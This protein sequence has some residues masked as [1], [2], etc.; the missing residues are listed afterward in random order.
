MCMILPLPDLLPLSWRNVMK[1]TRS[2][3][4]PYD[5]KRL[6]IPSDKSSFPDLSITEGRKLILQSFP[7]QQKERD[8]SNVERRFWWCHPDS[9]LHSVRERKRAI[10]SASRHH[11]CH[12]LTGVAIEYERET[13]STVKRQSFLF[14][15]FLCYTCITSSWSAWSPRETQHHLTLIDLRWRLF[16]D[17]IETERGWRQTCIFVPNSIRV[18]QVIFFS[19]SDSLMSLF[20]ALSWFSPWFPL[21]ILFTRYHGRKGERSPSSLSSPDDVPRLRL[22]R[23]KCKWLKTREGSSWW[24]QQSIPEMKVLD[25]R[26]QDNGHHLRVIY[27]PGWEREEK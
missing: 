25:K 13:R 26:V 5:F 1:N 4:K 12:H 16:S 9:V 20:F 6:L 14:S 19:A 17:T 15:Y 18:S 7:A 21:L 11:K 24:L 8:D 22:R 27:N 3:G 2:E 23:E 10:L